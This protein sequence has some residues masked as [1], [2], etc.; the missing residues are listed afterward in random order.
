MLGQGESGQIPPVLGVLSRPV[1]FWTEA[2]WGVSGTVLFW[3]GGGVILEQGGHGILEQ[4]H[5]A[6]VRFFFLL[7]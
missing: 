1:L 3:G 2:F 7:S 4:G 5:S 6:T